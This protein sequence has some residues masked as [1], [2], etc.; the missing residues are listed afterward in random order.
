MAAGITD[1][2]KLQQLCEIGV[3][4]HSEARRDMLLAVNYR[5]V[6]EHSVFCA[7]TAAE[8]EEAGILSEGYGGCPLYRAE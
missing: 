1:E 5:A 6:A 4:T 2:Y 7:K 8:E 3:F